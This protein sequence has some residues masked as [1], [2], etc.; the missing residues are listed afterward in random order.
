MRAAVCRLGEML[1]IWV[2]R[3][4]MCEWAQRV[5]CLSRGDKA[6]PAEA[7]QAMFSQQS[8]LRI[9]QALLPGE[10]QTPP[11]RGQWRG[12][13]YLEDTSLNTREAE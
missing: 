10:H 9:D 5:E 8:M 7:E 12:C 2:R 1:R 4:R 13:L 11:R 6:R 3:G